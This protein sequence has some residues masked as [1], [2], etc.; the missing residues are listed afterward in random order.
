[1]VDVEGFFALFF[2]AN[3]NSRVAWG[4]PK[5]PGDMAQHIAPLSFG[6]SVKTGMRSCSHWV[7]S[8]SWVKI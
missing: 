2:E 3:T 4:Y 7:T 1:M 6:R 8:K 5:I